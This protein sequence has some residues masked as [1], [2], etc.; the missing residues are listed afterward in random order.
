MKK[1][2]QRVT[3]FV[4]TKKGIWIT[5]SIW[6]ALLV[7]LSIF[8]PSSRDY[9]VSSVDTL[10]DDAQ[11]V[12]ASEK[13]EEYF[14]S[15]NNLPAI[16]VLESDNEITAEDLSSITNELTQVE[17]NGLD[18]VIPIGQLPEQALHAF[19][20][21]DGSVAI[22]PISFNSSMETAELKESLNH[23]GSIVEETT[24]LDLY[25]TGPAGIAVDT[26]DLFKR[27]DVVLILATV[28]IVLVLLIVIYRSPLLALIPLLAAGIVFQVTSQL[29]G[30]FGKAGLEMSMQSVSIMT[31]LLFAAVTDYSLF[32]FSRFREELKGHQNKYEAM[33]FAMRGT[34]T[35]VFYSGAT[36]FA[37][38]I[39]LIFAQLGD[40]KNFAPIFGVALLVIMLA[41]VTLVPALFAFFGRKSFW[42]VVP[43]VGDRT[44]KDNAI[45]SKVGRFVTQ[46][47]VVSLILIGVFLIIS[48]INI[49][50]IKYEYDLLKSFPEDMPSRVGYE[51]LAEN[52]H[53]G[54]LA[55]T[56]ILF[57]ANEP[58]TE[59]QQMDLLQEL[60]KQDLVENVR[61]DNIADDRQV[62]TYS[63]TFEV[64]PY[65]EEA[66]NALEEIENNSDSI[67]DESNVSGELFY[68]GE[69]ADSVDDRSLNNRDLI[70]IVIIESL[71]IF[72]MLI[73]LTKSIKMPLY[74]V[75]TILI[76]FF[77]ALGIGTFLTELFFDIDTISNRVPVY[78]FIFLVALGIDYNII[79]VS[80]FL[81]ERNNHTLKKA[82]EL[83][84]AKTG[85]VISS[86]G[87]ILAATFAVLMTQPMQLLFVFG[88][89][90]AI[91]ILIDTFLV[92]GVLLPSLLVLLEKDK[93]KNVEKSTSK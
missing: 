34:G 71:L 83:S 79:L 32:V 55:T 28:G 89:I 90:V 2:L 17:I 5:L 61:I 78:A 51:I 36:V 22:L 48:S 60:N 37:A 46:K 75:G 42:P 19:F 16:L 10:P 54:D 1:I 53:E 64:N 63:L 93:N 18:E 76:S 68:A 80:R 39:I 74:M 12:I 33:K 57:E 27:A 26:T 31:I 77:A 86:A 66:M 87:I 70:L 11:S 40:Y 6:V 13:L 88:F 67:I 25:I 62:I 29:L 49:P 69:T 43:K 59:H 91:G 47:P 82:V 15:S 44:V 9:Q 38:M 3:D 14:P 50:N 24:N 45:W 8:A 58:L 23:I 85:G 4:A 65:S 21:E 92:R 73:F 81:E 52:F 72:G 7:L 56:T 84:V 41:S 20:S 30:L 35:P